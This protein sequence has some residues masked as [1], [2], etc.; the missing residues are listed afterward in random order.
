VAAIIYSETQILR[1]SEDGAVPPPPYAQTYFYLNALVAWKK[2]LQLRTTAFSTT[3]FDSLLDE[4]LVAITFSRPGVIDVERLL[5]ACMESVELLHP[6]AG[7]RNIKKWRCYAQGVGEGKLQLN[8]LMDHDELLTKISKLANEFAH[9]ATDTPICA[10]VP[11]VLYATQHDEEIRI[12]L[13]DAIAR[14]ATENAQ[15]FNQAKTNAKLAAIDVEQSDREALIR[16]RREM[17]DRVGSYSS[18][19]LASAVASTTKNASQFAA[20]QRDAGRLFG[21]RFGQAWHYPKFQ[22]DAKRNTLP[23]MKSVLATLSPDQQGWDRLQWFLESH[24]S[25]DGRTPLEVWKT[26]RIKVIAAANTERW[27]GRD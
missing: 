3:N 9:S 16:A 25:L 18:E 10:L 4:C 17:L 21:V 12:A 5:G 27:N 11:E 19:D 20:D 2:S 23:E 7:S 1:R 15:V 24:E 14:S 26:D 13:W 8:K 22:F 6:I